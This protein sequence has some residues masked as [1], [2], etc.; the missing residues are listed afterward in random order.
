MDSY[1]I[2]LQSWIFHLSL[3][4]LKVLMLDLWSDLPLDVCLLKNCEL[5]KN[6][7]LRADSSLTSVY[8][9]SPALNLSR[10]RGNLSMWPLREMA[11]N[12]LVKKQSHQR[13]TWKLS[14]ENLLLKDQIH[15]FAPIAIQ[16]GLVL[17]VE[18]A[19]GNLVPLSLRE[20]GTLHALPKKVHHGSS[21][22]RN[23]FFFKRRH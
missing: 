15:A 18:S 9:I 23:H 1:F 14:A 20:T 16:E 13:Q 11:I 4:W 3:L 10:N 5:K 6:G 21:Y 12:I 7:M 8:T 17:Y 2:F 19:N 22:K